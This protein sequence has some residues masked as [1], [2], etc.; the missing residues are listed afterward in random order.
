MRLW[1]TST[2]S[3]HKR[4]LTLAAMDG[5][6]P[7]IP[8]AKHGHQLV[9]IL[10]TLPEAALEKLNPLIKPAE[11]SSENDIGTSLLSL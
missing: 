3:K 2:Q 5:T 6:I 4:E 11:K 10:T 7:E 9:V 1:D 8:Q